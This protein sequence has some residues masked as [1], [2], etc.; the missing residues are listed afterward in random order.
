MVLGLLLASLIILLPGVLAD[1]LVGFLVKLLKTVGLDVIV[2]VAGE[3]GLVALL[4]IIG[5]G[6]H[7]LSDVT[8]E[9]VLA[10]GLGVELLALNVVTGETVLGVRNKET[11]V[12][13]TLHGTEDTGTGGGAGET[14]IKEDLEGAA[15]LT[16]DLD[17]LGDVVLTIGLLDTGEVLVE[18]KLLENT[19]GEQ[20]TGG[21]SGR[22]VGQTVGDAVRLELVGVRGHEDLVAGDLGGNDL[23]DDVLVG[24]ADDEA[25][26]GRIVLV[27]RLGDQPLTGIVIGCAG[28]VFRTL[29]EL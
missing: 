26:L 24:E 16:V 20:K 8:G 11:T 4:V 13:C 27:L 14:D 19:A 18:L 28:S 22:P 12:R 6:L 17:G 15:L 1:L 7:V 9:D 23:G 5:E 29:A 21:V 2:N 3:L 10:E 25:V